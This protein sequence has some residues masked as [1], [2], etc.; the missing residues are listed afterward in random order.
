MMNRDDATA[1]PPA[2]P[3]HSTAVLEKSHSEEQEGLIPPSSSSSDSLQLLQLPPPSTINPNDDK[4]S[5]NSTPIRS[6]ASE[7]TIAAGSRPEAQPTSTL[8]RDEIIFEN[9]DLKDKKSLDRYFKI[10]RG[11]GKLKPPASYIGYSSDN[12][13]LCFK[14]IRE[15]RRMTQK[16]Q[17]H[18]RDMFRDLPR[19]QKNKFCDNINS[20]MKMKTMRDE[21]GRNGEKEA[22][23]DNVATEAAQAPGN[24]GAPQ[25]CQPRPRVLERPMVQRALEMAKKATTKKLLRH[26]GFGSS[27]EERSRKID[28]VEQRNESERVVKKRNIMG[29]RPQFTYQSGDMMA[30][31][32]FFSALKKFARF[33]DTVTMSRRS[34][35]EN[36]VEKPRN[37]TLMMTLNEVPESSMNGGGAREKNFGR[38][39]KPEFILVCDNKQDCFKILKAFKA[40]FSRDENENKKDDY[41]WT[42]FQSDESTD[43][44]ST[45][46]K[47]YIEDEMKKRGNFRPR[48][49]VTLDQV[50]NGI[51]ENLSST[52]D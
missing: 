20:I 46:I 41:D 5:S 9:I 26:I 12:W 51:P 30:K 43:L 50:E 42:W 13:R 34:E 32:A 38:R 7:T 15:W 6:M 29:T 47:K 35:K 45:A 2:L 10:Q 17:E 14:K 33:S 24:Q 39:L 44:L 25:D 19:N 52:M 4:S 21:S 37:M 1:P 36:A 3:T 40:I 16:Q 31:R 49:T 28:E 22:G 27:K 18:E 23:S 8:T 48:K 11:K